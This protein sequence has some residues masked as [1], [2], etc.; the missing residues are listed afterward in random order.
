MTGSDRL[1]AVD[2]DTGGLKNKIFIN[3]ILR[4]ASLL[5]Q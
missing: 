3:V 2:T 4:R 1:D 5:H